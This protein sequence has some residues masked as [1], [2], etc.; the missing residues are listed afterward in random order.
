[1]IFL[2]IKIKKK[3]NTLKLYIKDKLRFDEQTR[4]LKEKPENILEN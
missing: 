4:F 1:M 3:L 2:E